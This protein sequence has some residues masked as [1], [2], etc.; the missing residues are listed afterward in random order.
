MKLKR[1][2]HVDPWSK[3]QRSTTHFC[4]EPQALVNVCLTCP[5]PTCRPGC[6]KRYENAKLRLEFGV[7]PLVDI[8]PPKPKKL[9]KCER[10]EFGTDCGGKVFCPLIEGS[11]V[12]EDYYDQVSHKS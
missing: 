11:C 3:I 10:C 4:N 9:S 12:K 8:E 2:Y 6:C 1:A 7:F 5:L